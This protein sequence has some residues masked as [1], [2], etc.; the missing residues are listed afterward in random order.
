MEVFQ[1]VALEFYYINL[2]QC[3]N[4]YILFWWYDG[5]GLTLVIRMPAKRYSSKPV[6]SHYFIGLIIYC[7]RVKVP[8]RNGAQWYERN[9]LKNSQLTQISLFFLNE[10]QENT[11]KCQS[12]SFEKYLDTSFIIIQNIHKLYFRLSCIWTITKYIVQ[13]SQYC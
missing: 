9:C 1:F 12:P 3:V 10:G 7:P 4:I 6:I 8:R 2:Y 13:H 11:N 5:Q